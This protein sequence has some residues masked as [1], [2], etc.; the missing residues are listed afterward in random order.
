[1]ADRKP[2]REGQRVQSDGAR[3]TVLR[4]EHTDDVDAQGHHHRKELVYVL[5]DVPDG[6]W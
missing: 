5:W 1:M 3:G 2:L 4:V 6:D